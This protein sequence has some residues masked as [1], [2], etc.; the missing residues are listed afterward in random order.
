MLACTIDTVACEIVWK[1]NGLHGLRVFHCFLGWICSHVEC[2]TA[3]H[4]DRYIDLLYNTADDLQQ[5][6]VNRDTSDV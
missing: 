4:N 5:Y 1:P 2:C 6:T 3:S